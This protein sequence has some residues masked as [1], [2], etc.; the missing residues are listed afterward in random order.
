MPRA[1]AESPCCPGSIDLDLS[2]EQTTTLESLRSEL[3]EAVEEIRTSLEDGEE[4]LRNLLSSK[5]VDEVQVSALVKEIGQLRTDMKQRAL[6]YEIQE[7]EILTEE[8]WEKIS[9]SRPPV[10][11]RSFA[12][13]GRMGH[14]SHGRASGGGHKFMH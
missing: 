6:E 12:G 3:H 10:A 5:E 2:K 4:D 13:R 11:P 8:Q 14:D 9:S 1:Y 7:R